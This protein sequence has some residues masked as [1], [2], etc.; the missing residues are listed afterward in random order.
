MLATANEALLLRDRLLPQ[1][2]E[3]DGF[4]D[5]GGGMGPVSEKPMEEA[6]RFVERKLM[7]DTLS[8]QLAR[9]AA[10]APVVLPRGAADRR[11]AMMAARSGRARARAAASVSMYGDHEGDFD[12]EGEEEEKGAIERPPEAL[13]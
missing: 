3:E 1:R 13:I 11:R 2:E 5:G 7:G 8:R 6:R 4:D 10:P 12:D 9:P